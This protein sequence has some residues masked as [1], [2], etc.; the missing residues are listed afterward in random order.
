MKRMMGRRAPQDRASAKR[1]KAPPPEAVLV[2][3]ATGV[4]RR[5]CC[6]EMASNCDDDADWCCR[7]AIHRVWCECPYDLK[8][9]SST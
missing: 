1:I 2:P 8:D 7:C 6:G 9:G 3:V 4:Q 5:P